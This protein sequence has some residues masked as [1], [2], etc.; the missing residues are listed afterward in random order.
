MIS[1]LSERARRP[2]VH[3]QPRPP[4]Q[5]PPS[6]AV[7]LTSDDLLVGFFALTFAMISQAELDLHHRCLRS[8]LTKDDCRRRRLSAQRFLSELRA[9]RSETIWADWI[10]LAEARVRS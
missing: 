9:G 1:A 10:H 8:C 7:A 3:S 6:E 2:R 5:P 4:D